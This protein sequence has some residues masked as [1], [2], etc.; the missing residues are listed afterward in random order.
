GH[1]DPQT[2]A[3][4]VHFGPKGPKEIYFNYDTSRTRPWDDPDTKL[5]YDYRTWFPKD[6]AG[7]LKIDIMGRAPTDLDE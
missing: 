3:R 5:R 2:I 4:F 1:P 6:E 7:L